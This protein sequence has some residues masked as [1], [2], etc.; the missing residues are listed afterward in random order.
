MPRVAAVIALLL[1]VLSSMGSVALCSAVPITDC[2]NIAEPGSYFLKNDLV[3]AAS[4]PTYGAGG[5]CLVVSSSHVTIDL[6]GRTISVACP[7]LFPSACP[8]EFGPV[9]GIGIEIIGGVDNISISNGSIKNFAYGITAEA[10]HLSVANVELTAIFGLTLNNV[11]NSNFTNIAYNGADE[12]IHPS[13]GPILILNGGGRNT[14]TNVSGAVASDVGQPDGIMIVNSNA[15]LVFGANVTETSLEC[16]GT[17]V[18]VSDSSSYNAIINNN[19]FYLCG[20]GIEVDA[21]SRRNFIYRNTVTIASP[22]NVF[23][24]IDQNPDCG[25]DFWIDNSFSN[26]FAAG[27][28]S[29]NPTSCIH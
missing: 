26:M 25:S 15:N 18:L 10:K 9:G 11:Y 8:S 4:T 16:G 13:N 14:F 7:P 5:N 23:A 17:D 19:L 3:L 6:S 1:I 12:S 2:E 21:G 20:S 24:M 28:I 29:A 22:A 27:Q